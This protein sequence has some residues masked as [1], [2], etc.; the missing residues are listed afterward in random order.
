[1][2]DLYVLGTVTG[3]NQQPTILLDNSVY[4]TVKDPMEQTLTL[5]GNPVYGTVLKGRKQPLQQG[6]CSC[7]TFIRLVVS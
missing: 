5:F 7:S 2:D 3:N 1:M 4:F 6:N